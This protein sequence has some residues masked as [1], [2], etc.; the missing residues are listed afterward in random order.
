MGT[1]RSSRSKRKSSIAKSLGKVS[2]KRNIDVVECL[3]EQEVVM[4]TVGAL[5]ESTNKSPD[6][7]RVSLSN[8]RA[9]TGKIVK[10]KSKVL[11]SGGRHIRT[12]GSV[13]LKSGGSSSSSMMRSRSRLNL[14]NRSQTTPN[15]SQTTPNNMIG[16]TKGVTSFVQGK[17]KGPTLE[18]IHEQKNDE[19]RRKEE[20]EVEA[21]SRRE[22]MLKKKADEEREK[23]EA[24][25]K[26][27]QESRQRQENLRDSKLKKTQEREEKEK[28]AQLKKREQK[29]K[30]DA[31]KRRKET[32]RLAREQEEK[33]LRDEN[34][35]KAQQEKC[36][37]EKKDADRKKAENLK[38]KKLKEEQ[39]RLRKIEEETVKE[40]K[41]Q[42]RIAREK[43]ELRKM[44]DR[45]NKRQDLNSTYNKVDAQPS[46]ASQGV[47]SYDMTPARHELPPEPL[48]NEDDY[49]LED[50]RSDQETDDEDAPRKQ[51]PKWA[52][53][54]T[55]RTSLIRQCYM[56]IDLDQ[57]FNNFNMPDLS[58]MF[59]Q[60]RKRF[61]KRTSS[62]VW[63]HAPS[64]FNTSKMLK[65]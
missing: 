2:A 17:P 59:S 36:D 40:A 49:G 58:E 46:K 52:E 19:R 61:F 22:E 21:K 5:S 14:G 23:R 54:S 4:V 51:I 62:A 3:K 37:Q 18:E 15:K 48:V 25:I 55:L 26:R 11:A 56:P 28:L 7:T 50:L 20:K 60:Q 12:P 33:R 57:I 39:D 42:E 63:D 47:E 35:K 16:K 45:E 29:M 34:E 1:I 8:N 64:S 30:E 32:E 41:K 13:G 6:G 44:E 31:D 65:F 27:V 24:R 53:G 38:A 10:A 43:D 9:P